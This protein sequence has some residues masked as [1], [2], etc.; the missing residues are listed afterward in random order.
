[1]KC[2]Y[3][4]TDLCGNTHT[5]ALIVHAGT[6]QRTI[7]R[8]GVTLHL[9]MITSPQTLCAGVIHSDGTRDMRINLEAVAFAEQQRALNTAVM[10]F[11][12]H[13]RQ[14]FEARKLRQTS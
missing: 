9:T 1:M 3:V 12:Q 8:D 10:D 4:G 7:T 2:L 13:A 5:A 6:P 11:T 14:I